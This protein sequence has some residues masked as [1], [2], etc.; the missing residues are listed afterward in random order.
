M[1][2][3]V[4][5]HKYYKTNIKTLFL[6]ERNK[7]VKISHTFN[8]FAILYSGFTAVKLKNRNISNLISQSY[9]SE[10]PSFSSH[11]GDPADNV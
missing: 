8:I 10:N 2:K 5:L 4:P 6:A 11:Q 9:N 3:H 1:K 7:T